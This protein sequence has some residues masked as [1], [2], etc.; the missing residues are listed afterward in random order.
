MLI[1]ARQQFAKRVA[2]WVMT[3]TL[4]RSQ[5]LERLE[6]F[7]KD[8]DFMSMILAECASYRK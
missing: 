8:E 7:G 1:D 5:V 4:T 3:M 6:M 2:S